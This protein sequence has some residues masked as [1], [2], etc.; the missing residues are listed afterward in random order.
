MACK[1]RDKTVIPEAGYKKTLTHKGQGSW[2][3]I[4][5]LGS[6]FESNIQIGDFFG[7]IWTQE[8]QPGDQGTISG[9]RGCAS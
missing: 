1:I 8:R 3:V 4:T 6:F 5:D 7:I 2:K 9:T